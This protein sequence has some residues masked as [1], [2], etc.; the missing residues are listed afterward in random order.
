MPSGLPPGRDGPEAL[1][2]L[3]EDF[4]TD[5]ATVFYVIDRDDLAAHRFDRVSMSS[6]FH[7]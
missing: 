2:A 6:D 5:V 4:E 1:L 7:G 3:G